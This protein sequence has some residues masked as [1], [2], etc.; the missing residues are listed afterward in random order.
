MNNKNKRKILFWLFAILLIIFL[1]GNRGFRTLVRNQ[2]Q[3]V[4][5]KK[6]IAQFKKE[7]LLLQKQVNL[8]ENDL[9]TIE[10]IARKQLGMTYPNEIVYIPQ[11]KK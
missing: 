3:M 4:K 9:L 2:Y 5:L 10:S 1:F 8:L 11:E 6:E 7:N